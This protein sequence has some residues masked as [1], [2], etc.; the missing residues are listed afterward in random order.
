MILLKNNIIPEDHLDVSAEQLFLPK[1]VGWLLYKWKANPVTDVLVCYAHSK[2]KS[3]M[4]S[5]FAYLF[6]WN[7]TDPKCFCLFTGYVLGIWD[8]LSAKDFYLEPSII[9]RT[10]T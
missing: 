6:K 3:S 10:F 7:E 4:F 9:I 1:V 5:F 2:R 8:H